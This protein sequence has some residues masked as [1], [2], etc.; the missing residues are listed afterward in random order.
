M[1]F[2]NQHDKAYSSRS[3]S[4]LGIVQ[5]VDGQV[6]VVV[7]QSVG[8]SHTVSV[9]LVVYPWNSEFL[10]DGGIFVVGMGVAYGHAPIHSSRPRAVVG[11]TT[12]CPPPTNNYL[13]MDWQACP[14]P[15]GP[16]RRLLEQ[17]NPVRAATT[18]PRIQS[19]ERSSV[20]CAQTEKRRARRHAQHQ[21]SLATKVD[22]Q[23]VCHSIERRGR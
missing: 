15:T 8:I 16:T 17:G 11:N 14:A 9:D 13:I 20:A 5:K 18:A 10:V 22:K 2:L 7:L 12:N 1:R 4:S 23:S 21:H 3:T 19:P 6:V